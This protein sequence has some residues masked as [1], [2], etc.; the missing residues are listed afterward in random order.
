MFLRNEKLRVYLKIFLLRILSFFVFLISF[1]IADFAYSSNQDEIVLWHSYRG[2][3]EKAL[4]EVVK[5][6]EEAMPDIRIRILAVPYEVYADKIKNSIPRGHGPDLFIYAHELIGNWAR[7]GILYPYGNASDK[8]LF[9]EF[10][11]QTVEPLSYDGKIYAL[12]LAFKSLALFYNSSLIIKPPETIDELLKIALNYTEPKTGRYGLLVQTDQFYSLFPFFTLKGGGIKDKSGNYNLAM[13]GNSDGLELVKN[14]VLKYRVVPEEITGALLTQFFSEGKSP[15]AINGPWFIG[16]IYGKI[17][18]KVNSFPEDEKTGRKMKPFLTIEGIFISS[19]SKKIEIAKRVASFLAG[20]ESARIRFLR[21][22]QCV[23]NKSIISQH[24]KSIEDSEAYKILMGFYEQLPDTIPMPNDPK[25]RSVWVPMKLAIGKVI[26]G[27]EDPSKALVEAQRLFIA[28]TAPPPEP[29]NPGVFILLLSVIL[30][31]GAG[32]AVKKGIRENIPQRIVKA[33]MIYVYLIPGMLATALLVFLP[34]LVGASVSL[35]SHVEGKFTFVGL[36]NFYKILFAS[37]FHIFEPMNFYTTLIVTILW[38]IANL[39]LH[40]S[41]GMSI[42]LLLEK[43]WIKLRAFWRILLIV[44]WAIPNYITALIWKGMFHKQLGSINAILGLLG[45]EPVGW[46][47]RFS[48][49]FGAN[50]ITNAWLGF[51][52]MMVVTLGALQSIPK[53]LEESARVDGASGW[54]I[55]WKIKFP[56]LKPALLPAIILG[57]IWTFN[58]FNVIYLVSG[59]EPGGATDILISE[60]YRW[61]FERQEQYGYASAYAVLIFGI[62][63]LLARLQRKVIEASS[64]V[65]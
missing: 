49:A 52:F 11:P 21:G 60:A 16:E 13:Q 20:E 3:E 19:R 12:P 28:Y 32:F 46:F 9:R 26:R 10:L 64:D 24:S 4:E 43:P 39:I 22:F 41:T 55:F 31:I 2:R 61:A 29:S 34:F 18:F 8:S 62:L 23:A 42:A 58:M 47:S 37:D 35:F 54:T 51:P 33:R 45:V 40:V 63:L 56:L 36:K 48:T 1:L 15:F 6:I 65:R 27:E 17:P 5:K 25:M 14:L 30:L 44:P 57:T 59:G 38:T 50:L 7:S 53:E